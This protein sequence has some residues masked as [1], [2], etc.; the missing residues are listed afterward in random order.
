MLIYP[1]FE[2][3]FIV[4]TDA[5]L[6]AI[7]GVLS[8]IGEDGQEHPIAF[9]SRTLNAHERNYTVTERECL[10]VIHSYKQFRVY[11]HGRRFKVVTDHSSLRWLQNLKEPEGRLA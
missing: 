7:G 1:D 4:H 6:V 10:A 11:L 5:S 3:E 8:Q 9:C 2:K